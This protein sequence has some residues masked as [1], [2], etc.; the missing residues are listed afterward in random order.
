MECRVGGLDCSTNEK[1]GG[2]LKIRETEFVKRE[3]RVCRLERSSKF[4]FVWTKRFLWKGLG[5]SDS[6]HRVDT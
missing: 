6:V 5:S 4:S 2:F 1:R 3:R